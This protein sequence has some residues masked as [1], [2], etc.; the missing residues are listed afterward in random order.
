MLASREMQGGCNHH[1]T[2]GEPAATLRPLPS[3]WVRG[4][5]SKMRRSALP[6]GTPP[7]GRKMSRGAASHALEGCPGPRKGE[8][9]ARTALCPGSLGQ[10]GCSVPAAPPAWLLQVTGSRSIPSEEPGQLP[11][12]PQRTQDRVRVQS[13]SEEQRDLRKCRL[14]DFS[15]KMRTSPPAPG[16]LLPRA[17]RA[18]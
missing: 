3:M 16:G 11:H 14:G 4:E 8:R 12:G 1:S 9:P 6:P 10:P 13:P 5:A 15:P 7:C 18:L 2:Q 17:R